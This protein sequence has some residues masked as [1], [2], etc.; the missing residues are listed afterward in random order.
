MPQI[1]LLFFA[2]NLECEAGVGKCLWLLGASRCSLR[3]VN[4]PVFCVRG[5]VA[6]GSKA[7]E[8]VP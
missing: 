6:P 7:G 2:S 8:A 3:G 1:V 5:R 4:A